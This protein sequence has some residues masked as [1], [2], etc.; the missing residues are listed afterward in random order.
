MGVGKCNKV[1]KRFCN[2]LFEACASDYFT[3]DSLAGIV[4]PCT[5]SSLLCS[6]LIDLVTS[7][8]ALCKQFSGV[9]VESAASKD[10]YDGLP[11]EPLGSCLR[12]ERTEGSIFWHTSMVHLLRAAFAV[13]PM[14]GGVLVL[15]WGFRRRRHHAPDAERE[16]KVAA[17]RAKR[18]AS[19]DRR[20]KMR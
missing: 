9:V 10:C 8:Q 20:S 4:Q 13:L 15:V 19:L 17:L 14:L 5:E 3:Y 11:P 7:G 6:P 16:Q 12:L 18:L 2:A 1:C